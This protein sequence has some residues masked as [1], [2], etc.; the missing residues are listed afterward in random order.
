[1]I[2]VE[3][4]PKVMLSPMTKSDPPKFAV[5]LLELVETKMRYGSKMLKTSDRRFFRK[6][7]KSARMSDLR[8]RRVLG[9]AVFDCSLVTNFAPGQANKDVFESHRPTRGPAHEG[10]VFMLLDQLV[11]RIGRKHVAMVDDCD[12]VAH[13][14][15]FLH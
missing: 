8:I 3:A 15:G 2:D 13:G 7:M 10:I 12:P 14:L 11:W 1:M 9:A 5:P 4:I 6:T